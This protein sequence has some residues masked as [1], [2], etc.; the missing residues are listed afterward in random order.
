MLFTASGTDTQPL[1]PMCQS[2]AAEVQYDYVKIKIVRCTTCGLWRTCPRLSADELTRYYAEHYYNPERQQ[3][4]QYEKWRDANKDVWSVNAEVVA[5]E[6]RERRL[7]PSLLDVGCGHGFFMEQCLARGLQA[8]GIETSPH[9]IEYATQTLKLDVRQ[10]TLDQIPPDEYYDIVTLW[11]VL[12]H[13]P[14]PLL[15]MR[16]V[17]AHLKPGGMVWVMTPN[18]NALERFLKGA[19][20]FNFLNQTH[21]T[22]FHRRTLKALLERAGFKNVRRYIH[23]G[24]GTRS[25]FAAAAQYAAR[26]LCLGTELR[27]IAEK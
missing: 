25:G 15:A 12:E 21:L 1:C 18:T 19:Q 7:G 23:W 17:H 6:A 5:K 4:G 2:A 8:R 3:A 27:F 26:V 22:H 11:G 14:D 13:L 16:Q 20:Y 9:A 10:L 24:G